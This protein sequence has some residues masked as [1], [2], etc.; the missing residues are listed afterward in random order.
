M[1]ALQDECA[2][3]NLGSALFCLLHI[4]PNF[5]FLP[6]STREGALSGAEDFLMAKTYQPSCL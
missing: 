6:A 1:S 3:G 4:L 2:A 5:I